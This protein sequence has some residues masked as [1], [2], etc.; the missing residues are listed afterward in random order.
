MPWS[1][2]LCVALTM[3]RRSKKR[4]P[5]PLGAR[6]VPASPALLAC[7]GP[8][9][10]AKRQRR[11]R[12]G[13]NSYCLFSASPL[14]PV[15]L[16]ARRTPDPWHSVDD[17]QGDRGADR[18]AAAVPGRGPPSPRRRSA[19]GGTGRSRANHT[20]SPRTSV[21]GWPS[22]SVSTRR[23][24]VW[25]VPVLPQISISGSCAALAVPV[26]ELTTWYIPRRTS[27]RC[28][29]VTRRPD[30]SSSFHRCWRSANSRISSGWAV[31][32]ARDGGHLVGD[33]HGR[34]RHGP[35]AHG[36]EARLGQRFLTTASGP[37]ASRAS[38]PA[39]PCRSLGRNRRPSATPSAAA[40]R[41]PRRS[42]RRTCCRNAP[43]TPTTSSGPCAGCSAMSSSGSPVRRADEVAG[44]V[45]GRARLSARP[46]PGRPG[47]HGLEDRAGLIRRRHRP[48]HSGRS[49]SG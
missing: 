45:L 32:A 41:A 28:S 22:P 23:G 7:P 49:L 5:I 46:R 42:C 33:L 30:G 18:A 29:A 9:A 4:D 47:R 3:L 25:A 12:R 13:T 43:A 17:L 16:T 8:H 1:T 26:G 15:L 14:L 11:R 19:A 36:D 6:P 48:V 38:P 39:G 31:L 37:A 40:G 44:A 27:S 34:G 35:L 24:E 2:P 10:Y 21:S 20:V